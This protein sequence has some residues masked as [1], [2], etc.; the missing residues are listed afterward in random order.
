MGAGKGRSSGGGRRREGAPLGAILALAVAA[1]VALLAAEFATVASVSLE[2][3]SCTVIYDASPELADRC[4]L[5]GFERHGGA[6][7][8]LALVAAGAGFAARTGATTTGGG[9]LVVVAV[10]VL[11]LALFGDLPVTGET[12]AIGLDFEGATA[13][14]GPGFFLEL[15]GGVLALAAGL[16][17]LLGARSG[18]AGASAPTRRQRPAR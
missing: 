7:I 17:A 8:L 15:V 5:S 14:P 10:V 6:L 18:N 3:E 11:G 16:L 12:G 1:A 13:K 4:S 9:V 2:G